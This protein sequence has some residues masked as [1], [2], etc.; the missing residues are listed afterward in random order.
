MDVL[1]SYGVL[2]RE[3]ER[4]HG[5]NEDLKVMVALMKENM[6]LRSRSSALEESTPRGSITGSSSLRT[7]EGGS[8]KQ[9]ILWDDTLEEGQLSRELLSKSHRTSSPLVLSALSKD[10][11]SYYSP[12]KSSFQ[13][14]R[15]TEERTRYARHGTTDVSHQEM[16]RAVGE[17]A[18]QLD[19]RILSYVFLGRARLYGFTVSNIPDKIAQVSTNKLSGK[20]DEALRSHMTRRYAELME[21]LKGLGYNPHLHPRFSEHIVNTYGILKQRPEACTAQLKG[22]NDPDSLRKMV[23]EVV[24]VA[25]LKDTL[26]LLSCL[27]YLARQDEKALFIW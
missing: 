18:F 22:Y 3:S 4:L 6:D 25:M 23:I 10:T 27:C 12:D 19:R 14:L 16:E 9:S 1:G 24:P 7:S 8:G 21:K 11:Y 2:K 17:I 13:P 26:L 5:E 15:V 20:V